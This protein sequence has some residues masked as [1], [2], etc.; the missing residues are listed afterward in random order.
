[1]NNSPTQPFAASFPVTL[2][3]LFF[4]FA[5]HDLYLDL[6]DVL[7]LLAWVT[8]FP[9][10]AE[11][12]D[13]GEYLKQQA[14]WSWELRLANLIVSWLEVANQA[15]RSHAKTPSCFAAN[16]SAVLVYV[17]CFSWSVQVKLSAFT[18]EIAVTLKLLQFYGQ[19]KHLVYATT[20]DNVRIPPLVCV[21]DKLH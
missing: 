15:R 9:S 21:G 20:V 17:S 3:C 2:S 5:F 7:N 6:E 12:S 11:A 18:F 13:F 4:C 8:S 10:D 16:L 1:M 14:K 19:Q